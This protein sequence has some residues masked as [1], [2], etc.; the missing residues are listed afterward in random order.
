MSLMDTL[1]GLVGKGRDAA[2]ENAEKIH[3]AVDKAGGFIDE[4]TG[5]K[6]S[7][8]INKGADALKNAV[9]E[10]N[11]PETPPPAPEPPAEPQG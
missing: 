7:D 2:A 10:Q 3:E 11:Q 4:K 1:K 5:G 9:P 8:Q 6:Y